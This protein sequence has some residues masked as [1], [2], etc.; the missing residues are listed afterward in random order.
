MSQPNLPAP[1]GSGEFLLY[2]SEDGLTRVEVRVEADTVWLSQK[3]M[4]ELFQKDVRTVS[5][6]IRNI[7]EENELQQ[8]GTIRKF[9]IVQTDGARQVEREVEHYNLGLKCLQMKVLRNHSQTRPVLSINL[10][11]RPRPLARL[12]VTYAPHLSPIGM[13]C[14]KGAFFSAPAG[15]RRMGVPA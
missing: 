2:Q 14:I 12:C 6:H 10:L 7:F 13:T 8:E 15:R 9:R 5:E 1:T 3:A 11:P 4:A